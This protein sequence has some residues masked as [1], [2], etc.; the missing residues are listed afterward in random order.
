MIDFNKINRKALA[1]ARKVKRHFYLHDDVD[2][3]IEELYAV[4]RQL[5]ELYVINDVL[6]N[7]LEEMDKAMADFAFDALCN[8]QVPMVLALRAGKSKR[9]DRVK[10][11]YDKG[12]WDIN[13]VEM[14]VQAG[15]ITDEEFNEIVGE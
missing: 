7:E 4:H 12:Y 15:W 11:W 14:A 8:M 13:M 3:L 2:V 10:Q 9:Y 5:A 1:I 6:E